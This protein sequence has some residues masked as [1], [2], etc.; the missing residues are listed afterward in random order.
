LARNSLKTIIF[1][2]AV[3]CLAC[4]LPSLVLGQI[5]PREIAQSLQEKY[6]ATTSMSADFTQKTSSDVSR[7]E[8]EG[9]GTM[10]LLKPG[11]MRWDYKFPDRQVIV[12]DGQS[13]T[14]YFAQENQMLVAPAK[15]YLESDMTY[16]FFA[17]SGNIL[18][19]F[20]VETPAEEDLRDNEATPLLRLTPNKDH[21]QI[22]YI[23]LW[24]D[25]DFIMNRLKIVDKFGSMTDIRFSNVKLNP[26]ISEHLF[27]FTPPAG[28]EIIKQ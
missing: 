5:T 17:G 12:C 19:N 25:D 8:K 11:R 24:A 9:R 21:P 22:D 28:T 1:L 4:L 16:S 6:D 7:R 10:V 18:R 13:I 15:Q 20:T 3:L 14:M 23:L 26:K 2:A 27:S